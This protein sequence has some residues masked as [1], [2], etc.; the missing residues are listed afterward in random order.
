M[1]VAPRTAILIQVRQIRVFL[2]N[3]LGSKIKS[4]AVLPSLQATRLFIGSISRIEPGL[5][6]G[7]GRETASSID[8]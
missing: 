6:S 7:R 2:E 1:A 5:K 4:C 8:A 3:P